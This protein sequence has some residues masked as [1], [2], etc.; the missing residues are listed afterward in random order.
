MKRIGLVSLRFNRCGDNIFIDGLPGRIESL[1]MTPA[2]K[3]E[4]LVADVGGNSYVSARPYED[5]GIKVC[6]FRLQDNA[7]LASRVI[8]KNKGSFNYDPWKHLRTI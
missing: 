8:R 6:L 2:R 5:E 3:P 4:D 1:Q 7:V